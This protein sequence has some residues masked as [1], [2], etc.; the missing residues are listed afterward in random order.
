MKSMLVVPE[1]YEYREDDRSSGI[2]FLGVMAVVC[3]LFPIAVV[4][5]GLLPTYHMHSRFLLFYAP[6]VALLLLGYLLYIRELIG[7]LFFGDVLDAMA[8]GDSAYVD[9]AWQQKQERSRRLR[10]GVIY[11]IPLLLVGLSF[12]CVKQYVLRFNDSVAL[13][14]Q[15]LLARL[16]MPEAMDSVADSTPRRHRPAESTDTVTASQPIPTSDPEPNMAGR[17]VVLKALPGMAN[18]PNPLR[19]YTLKMATID[20]IPYFMELTALYIGGIV[21]PLVAVFMVLL[22]EHARRE[23]GLTE[24]EVLSGRR[25]EASIPGVEGAAPAERS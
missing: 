6:V 22:K 1:E 25:E 12:Y 24:R 19:T 17:M 11:L 3:G 9:L 8:A 20:D 18:D 14:S 4:S 7:R 15:L 10:T 5:L 2:G 13:S 16:P 23:L 21:G